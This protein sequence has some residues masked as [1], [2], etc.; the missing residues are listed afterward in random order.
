MADGKKIAFGCALG[1]AV[2][3]LLMAAAAAAC[4]VWVWREGA[5]MRDEAADP[6]LRSARA[7]EVL[8]VSQVPDGYHVMAAFAVPFVMQTA[9]LSDVP[10][11]AEGSVE[12]FNE[13]GFVYFEMLGFGQD[14]Q[15]L[16]DYFEGR[17]DDIGVLR[18]NGIQTDI[19]E[20]LE[21]G[22][23]ELP[24]ASAM[25]VTQR[26][27]VRVNRFNDEGLSALALI[28]CPQDEKRRI[29][30]WFGPEAEDIAGTPADPAALRAFLAQFGFCR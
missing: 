1:C 2:V 30:M 5:Q 4:G 10:P 16:R 8:G 23:L 24:G 21:R 17:T 28:D 18:D 27:R 25:Y 3:V 15:Q 19:D 26:G 11:D 20:V 22:V 7:L 12:G 14:E 6:E 29:A 13:R 9:I